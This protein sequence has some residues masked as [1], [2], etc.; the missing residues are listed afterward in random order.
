M[1]GADPYACLTA[2]LEHVQGHNVRVIGGHAL[3]A[4]HIPRATVDIDL[5][6][7]STDF[8]ARPWPPDP[9]RAIRRADSPLDPIDAVV[10][11]W[12]ED[13]ADPRIPVQIIVLRRP[14]LAELLAQPG[15]PVQIGDYPLQSV[16]PVAL[17][18]LKLYAGG[19]RDRADVEL[20]A[21]LPDWPNWKAEVEQRLPALPSAI[22]RTWE[23]W[24]P[25]EG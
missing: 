22:R 10:E 16:S 6:V 18:V 1:A 5:L 4:L 25:G 8:L 19:P 15:L 11:W 3:G 23:R 20:I 24:R 7:D 21:S 13:E 12:P 9:E 17:I 2:A 14:W